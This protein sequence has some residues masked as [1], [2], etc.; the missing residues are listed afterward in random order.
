DAHRSAP[1]ETLLGAALGIPRRLWPWWFIAMPPTLSSMAHAL[2]HVL[3]T[4]PSI[5]G[6]GTC[7]S[8][9][10]HTVLAGCQPARIPAT[11]NSSTSCAVAQA[12]G[13][14]KTSREV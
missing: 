10:V 8:V 1:H 7:W 2:D 14:L 3:S 5:T 6:G 9:S 13:A 4:F 12:Q 11:G